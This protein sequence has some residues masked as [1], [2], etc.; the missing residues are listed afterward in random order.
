VGGTGERI[1]PE[2][3]VGRVRVPRRAIEFLPFTLRASGVRV[4]GGAC[5]G[6]WPRLVAVTNVYDKRPWDVT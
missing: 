6:G 3:V 4:F 5:F 1:G 2:P